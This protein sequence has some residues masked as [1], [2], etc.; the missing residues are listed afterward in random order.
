[1]ASR[2]FDAGLLHQ[3]LA[4]RWPMSDARRAEAVEHV[5]DLVLTEGVKPSTKI[6]A[7][8]ALVAASK[9]DV[10]AAKAFAALLMAS[11]MPD[12]A[13]SIEQGP[14]SDDDLRA[15]LARL[16]QRPATD[17]AGEGPEAER[18]DVGPHVA[19]AVEGVEVA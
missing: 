11:K 1:M 15:G 9:V 3:A 13:A 14:V 5:F 2:D 17:E 6:K 4:Q 7:F 10:E 19:S 12:S 18:L 8:Q 16:S